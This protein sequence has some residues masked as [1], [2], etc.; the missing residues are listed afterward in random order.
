MELKK[1]G[2]QL[3]LADK[4]FVVYWTSKMRETLGDENF[5]AAMA[6]GG[7]LTFEEAMAETR[8]WLANET[9]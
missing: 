3:D 8:A 5:S 1:K 6:E 9:N 2:Y 4:K 7:R